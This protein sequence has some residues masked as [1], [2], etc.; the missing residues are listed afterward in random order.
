[1][2]ARRDVFLAAGDA[3]VARR[4]AFAAC[5][6]VFGAGVSGSAPGLLR[7]GRFVTGAPGFGGEAAAADAL[8]LRRRE[9]AAAF[10]RDA[11][12]ILVSAPAPAHLLRPFCTA[13]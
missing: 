3:F 7:V 8:V 9:T 13:G 6:A 2:V 12:G 10:P 1:L 4:S 5:G 11:S